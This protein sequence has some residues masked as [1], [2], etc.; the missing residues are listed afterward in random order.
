MI[1]VHTYCSY[2]LSPSGFQYG[3]F[4]I[5]DDPKEGMYYLSDENKNSIVSSAF[6]YSIVKRLKGKL[7]KKNTFICFLAFLPQ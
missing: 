6:D 4:D 2:K 5:I 3:T 1:R 7:P